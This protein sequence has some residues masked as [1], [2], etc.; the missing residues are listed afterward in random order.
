MSIQIKPEKSQLRIIL[1]PLTDIPVT[2]ITGS[3]DCKM[4][5]TDSNFAEVLK[6]FA[7]Y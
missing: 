1:T 4:Q 5:A 6:R 7:F 3:C 2:E